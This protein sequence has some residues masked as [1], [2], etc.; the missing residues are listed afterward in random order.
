MKKYYTTFLFVLALSISTVTGQS[1]L[2]MNNE[3]K[4]I[5][6]EGRGDRNNRWVGEYRRR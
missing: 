5:S 4:Y 2:N 6:D 3:I 1:I